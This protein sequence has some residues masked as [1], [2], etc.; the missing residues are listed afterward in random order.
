[1]QTFKLSDS[2][3]EIKS[4][5]YDRIKPIFEKAINGK[6]SKEWINENILLFIKTNSPEI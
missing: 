4:K 1:M 2:V 5:I 6:I 3:S